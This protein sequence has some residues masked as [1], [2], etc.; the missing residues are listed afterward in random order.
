MGDR[1]PGCFPA[2]HFDRRGIRFPGYPSFGC[3]PS[4]SKLFQPPS[5]ASPNIG[6]CL[7]GNFF[8]GFWDGAGDQR[9]TAAT[10]P[11]ETNEIHLM[12]TERILA[13]WLRNRKRNAGASH[14]SR[15]RKNFPASGNHPLWRA[16]ANESLPAACP[17][18]TRIKTPRMEVRM[19]PSTS[20]NPRLSHHRFVVLRHSS[21]IV[22]RFFGHRALVRHVSL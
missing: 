20:A 10:N 13:R 15:P 1:S 2:A 12:F 5:R 8:R 17:Q 16:S 4:N 7:I 22:L 11:R 3:P 9:S 14:A 19:I 6:N 21:V 18:E